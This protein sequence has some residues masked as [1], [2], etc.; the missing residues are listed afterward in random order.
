MSMSRYVAFLRGINVGGHTAK[1]A[2]LEKAFS[3]LR[4]LNVSVIKQSG[5][6]VFETDRTDERGLEQD[7][8]KSLNDVLGFEVKVFLRALPEL[9]AMLDTHPFKGHDE[10]GASFLVTFLH[11]EPKDLPFEFPLTIPRST[12][13]IVSSQGREVFSVTHGGGEGALP[14]QFIE[15][16]LKVKSTTRNLR[17]IE[18]I[19]S[20]NFS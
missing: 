9:K 11:D 12:A 17:T 20:D 8:E 10:S 15:T 6:I 5:N 13:N 7:I 1:K 2:Q 3:A 19:F 4:F 18:G 16:K 14:N